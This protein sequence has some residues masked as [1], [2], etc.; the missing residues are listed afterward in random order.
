[1][2]DRAVAPA[3]AATTVVVVDDHA[4][5]G[6]I[7]MRIIGSVEG[8]TA[9]AWASTAAEGLAAVVA[10]RPDVV[11]VDHSL[12][13]QSGGDLTRR[14]RKV[15]P[16]TKVVMLTGASDP[17]AVV[18]AVDAGC[19]GFLEKTRALTEL[20]RVLASV[21]VGGREF[22]SE[23]L[24]QLPRMEE[25]VVH[26]Q[27]IV[28]LESEAVIGGEALVRWERSGHGVLSPDHF[29]A[30]AEETGLIVPLGWRV[31]SEAARQT[32]AWRG[33]LD[34]AEAL[35]I[36]VNVSAQQ[37]VRPDLVERVSEALLMAALPARA[38]V[39]EVTET[40]VM[41]GDPATAKQLQALSA[42]GVELRVDD[43]GTG[44]SSMVNLRRFP[45]GAL[46]IDRTF[47]AGMLL[48]SEDAEIVA[49]SIRLARSLGL[50]SVAEGVED[51]DQAHALLALGCELAQGYLWSR[52]LP[53]QDFAAWYLARPERCL[54]GAGAPGTSVSGA[55]VK[56]PAK[57]PGTGLAY[58]HCGWCHL[59]GAYLVPGRPV[60]R[61]KYCQ[62]VMSF[63]QSVH[64]LFEQE[65]D[66]YARR[67]AGL[68]TTRRE[69]AAR[70]R[71]CNFDRPSS[72]DR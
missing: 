36:S 71:E 35:S 59:K 67:L 46:K 3:K 70:C 33:E 34:G 21:A 41:D 29:I 47:V 6:E 53:P 52:P 69:G 22:P 24:E 49:A 39:I 72:P 44:Y 14:I 45:F 9:V 8:F 54:G 40:G 1:M 28:D 13:D 18:E 51:Q 23:L 2:S 15:A 43:F 61:C 11:V 68:R 5:V 55:R 26:Y 10:H 56:S 63:P 64:H 58:E 16:A 30:R 31:L 4:M 7:V 48:H 27:P 25:L 60:L 20:V 65:L 66:H 57:T 50:R 12:P 38:L 17:R 62:A 37:L 32:S 19:D 42:L